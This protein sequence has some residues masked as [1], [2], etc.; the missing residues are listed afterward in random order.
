MSH[1]TTAVILVSYAA[2]K[3]M[4]EAITGHDF[5][6]GRGARQSFARMDEENDEWPGG[7]KLMECDVYAAGLNYVPGVEIEEW[8]QRLPW[9]PGDAA[10]L[11]WECNGEKRGSMS[12]GWVD[13]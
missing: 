12:T 4:R 8:F 2:D 1:V 6:A 10:F 5:R 11:V 13:W 7:T 9:T 3:G